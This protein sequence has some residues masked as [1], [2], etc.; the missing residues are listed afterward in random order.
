MPYLVIGI[1]TIVQFQARRQHAVRLPSLCSARNTEIIQLLLQDDLYRTS[2][3]WVAVQ[4]EQVLYVRNRCAS[5]PLYENACFN[6]IT[7]NNRG[8]SCRRECRLAEVKPWITRSSTDQ[9]YHLRRG[10]CRV[11]E[12]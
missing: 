5:C 6:I 1:H 11:L 8:I 10:S 3:A 7:C 2:G 12:P 9:L 4:R